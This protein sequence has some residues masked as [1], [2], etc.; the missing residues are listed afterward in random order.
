MVDLK[1]ID[2]ERLSKLSKILSKVVFVDDCWV[3]P[4]KVRGQAR[5][6]GKLVYV[7]R[8][9]YELWFDVKVES[10]V[11]RHLC[12]E[13]KCVNPYH[14]EPGTGV[15]NG[16]DKIFP[17]VVAMIERLRTLGYRVYRK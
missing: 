2:F 15:E 1:D 3:Y 16:R 14:L 10:E 12:Y 13:K 6:D 7:Y 8:L 5:F 11:M 4:S 9:T 17:P